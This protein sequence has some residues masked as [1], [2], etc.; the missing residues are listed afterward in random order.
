V[1]Q[2]VQE[3]CTVLYGVPTMFIGELENLDFGKYDYTSLR[4]G[5]WRI[6]CPTVMPRL[7]TACTCLR[8]DCTARS[9]RKAD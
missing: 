8:H 5:S 3:R 7:S 1:L 2:A 4:T 9:L 6:T